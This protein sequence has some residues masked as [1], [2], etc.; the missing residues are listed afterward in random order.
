MKFTD[1]PFQSKLDN[2]PGVGEK[3]RKLLLMHFKSM[4]E[5]RKAD[6][7]DITK[8]GIPSNIA[9]AILKHLNE[10]EQKEL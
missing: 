1:L 6:I 4:E 3:R 9:R 7:S 2:I 8:L 10:N 5:I